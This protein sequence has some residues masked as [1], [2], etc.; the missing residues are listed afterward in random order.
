MTI[1]SSDR[2]RLLADRDA[3]NLQ[4]MMATMS[5]KRHEVNRLQ[6]QRSSIEWALNRPWL[7]N[8]R[9]LIAQCCELGAQ[10]C[11]CDAANKDAGSLVI[12][13]PQRR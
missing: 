7:P 2:S 8:L 5:G 13:S 6:E 12:I 4:I 11:D 3:I 9:K 1:T 10:S